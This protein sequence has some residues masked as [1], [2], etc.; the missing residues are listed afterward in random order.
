MDGKDIEGIM[1]D[2]HYKTVE[3]SKEG[4]ITL[5]DIPC[6]YIDIVISKFLIFIMASLSDKQIEVSRLS[7]SADCSRARQRPHHLD[8]SRQEIAKSFGI[9]KFSLLRILSSFEK[10]GVIKINDKDIQIINS[11]LIL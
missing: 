2:M 1:K 4:I 9:W 7:P 3:F 6:R 11:K 10:E 8:R 5:A